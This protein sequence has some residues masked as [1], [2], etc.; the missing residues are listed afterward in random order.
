M[1]TSKGFSLVEVVV[2][3]GVF[4]AGVVAAVALL[5]QTTSSASTRL[6]EATAARVA[7]SATALVQNLRWEEAMALT[8]SE[9]PWFVDREGGRFGL[10]DEDTVANPF[11][12]G[13]L[14]RDEG[15][16]PAAGDA[17]AAYWAGWI[18]LRWPAVGA[19]GSEIAIENQSMLRT[20]LVINR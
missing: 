3:V 12:V 20:R 5:S 9:E 16:S 11:F 14:L 18:E 1:D 2:A 10:L 4:V 15:L 7:S 17:L 8:Q 13:R 19:G 6:E